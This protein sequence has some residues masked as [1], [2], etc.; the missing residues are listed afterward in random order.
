MI[1]INILSIVV[2]LCSLVCWVMEIVAAFKNEKSPL[3]G[4]LSIVPCLGLGGFIIG[5]VKHKEWGIT[6]LML[7]WSVVFVIS[8][9]LNVI[10]AAMGVGAAGVGDFAIPQ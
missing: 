10:G 3:L 8:I 1:I 9:V 2:G 4:I 5:W 6:Q 7:I